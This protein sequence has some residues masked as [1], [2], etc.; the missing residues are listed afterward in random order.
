MLTDENIRRLEALAQRFEVGGS[1][2]IGAAMS[3]RYAESIRAVLSPGTPSAA[4]EWRCFHCDEAFADAESAAVHFGKSERQNPICTIDAA[5]YRAMEQRMLRYN[6]EDSDLHREIYGL[7]AKHASELRRE[8]E[9]G[10]ALGLAAQVMI[11]THLTRLV[12]AL[13]KN[14]P[15]TLRTLWVDGQA[16]GAEI[17]DLMSNVVLPAQTE[18]AQTDVA[19][20]PGGGT[21]D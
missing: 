10:Y 19:L 8:E 7:R 1:T 9:K 4:R 21:H 18:R 6:E 20:L 15:K 16:V 14:H 2:L 11:D 5:E 12:H 3:A 13:A 17:V